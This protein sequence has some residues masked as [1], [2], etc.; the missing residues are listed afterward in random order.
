M[1][2]RE[3]HVGDTVI[4]GPFGA[5]TGL[6]VGSI[7]YDGHS[8][9]GDALAGTFDEDR[10]GTLVGRIEDLGRRYG[11]QMAL[12][13]IAAS[14]ES[15]SRCLEFV[16]RRSVLPMLINATEPEVRIA[17]LEAADDLGV[18]DR[19]IFASLNEDTADEELE[20]LSAHRP[21]GVMVLACD[22]I[23][24]TPE[25]TCRLLD[26][27]YLPMLGQIGVDVPI[28][29]TGVMDPPSVG[30]AIR[31]IE[32]VRQRYGFPAGCA[33]SNAFPQWSA[34]RALGRP[35]SDISLASALVA[36]RA[37]GADFLHYGIVERAAV[38]AHA[39]GTVEVFY[40]YAARELD[41]EVL[42]EHHPIRAM[43]RLGDPR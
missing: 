11:V 6:L 30:L 26:E 22:V 31:S 4:G 13:V 20:A 41:G 15:M 42:P 37:A 43:F 25:S 28:V 35:W 17:G 18:L 36:C 34:I 24:P 9:V 21:A 8:L 29:D 33:F 16:A 27:R 10:A 23:D 12:D 40:G 5:H 14:P 19:C 38:A 32:A 1:I 39:A 7:F 3:V 2:P